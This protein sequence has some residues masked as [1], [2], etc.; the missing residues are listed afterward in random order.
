[1]AKGKKIILNIFIIVAALVLTTLSI[2]AVDHI[3]NFSQSIIGSVF[4]PP[5]RQSP[6]PPEMVLVLSAAGDFCLDKYEASAGAGCLY[7]NPQNQTETALNLNQPDCRPVSRPHARP[8]VNISRDQAEVACAKAG[9]RLPTAVE[10]YW[11]ALG[12]PDK[13]QGWELADCQL[14]SNWPDQPGLTG[15]GANCRS[16]AG[17]YDMVCNVWEW[18]QGTVQNGYWQGRQLPAEGYIAGTD[19]Q[20][21]PTATDPKQP[22]LNYNNDY[23]W[24]KKS[25]WRAIARGGYW[26]NKDRAG[27]YALYMV[28]RPA[29]AG[30]GVG[31]RCLK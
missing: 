10:W 26:D 14:N 24:L 7:Q 12:T 30:P 31:F 6:C 3:H 19:G 21:M 28:S 4:S 17:A 8:W 2:D 27:I 18:V 11:A 9:K 20:G 5:G 1:M 22:D 16:A 25:G 15:T 29:F 23:F 13:N